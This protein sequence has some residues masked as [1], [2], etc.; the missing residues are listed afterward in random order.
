[1]ITRDQEI[2]ISPD[3]DQWCALRGP[4]L[5]EGESGFGATPEE[6]LMNLIGRIVGEG[7]VVTYD[8]PVS[9]SPV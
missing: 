2:R 4:D 8:S 7:E 5:Q 6:A 9:I 3:G 1:M